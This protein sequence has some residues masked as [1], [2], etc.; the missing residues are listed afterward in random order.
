MDFREKSS[1]R[2]KYYGFFKTVFGSEEYLD[3]IKNKKY[4]MVCT[5]FPFSAHYLKIETGRHIDTTYNGILCT[6]CNIKV[7]ETKY[8]FCLYTRGTPNIEYK[9]FYWPTLQKSRTAM[10]CK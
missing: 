8:H 1:E 3:S 2:L 9:F 6:S 4:K 5:K 7:F 10:E